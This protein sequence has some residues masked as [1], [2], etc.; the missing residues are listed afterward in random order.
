MRNSYRNSPTLAR[1]SQP[2]SRKGGLS[3]G[4]VV[5]I[6]EQKVTEVK[7]TLF[8]YDAIQLQE[9]EITDIA[10]CQTDRK[11]RTVTWLNIDGLHDLALITRLG[12][13]FKLS[14]LHQEDI[15]NTEQR[16]KMEAAGNYIYVVLKMLDYLESQQ[17][18]KI[19][20]VSFILG[21]N[22]VLSFQE[23]VGDVF[24]PVRERLRKANGRIR[25]MG[26]DY[27]LYALIDVV[28]DHYFFVLEKL[29]EKIEDIQDSLIHRPS[30][31]VLQGIYDLKRQ[32]IFIRKAVW[33][34]R[35]LVNALEREESRLISKS[36]KIYLR[37]VY[38]H[39]IQV[40]DTIETYREMLAEMFEIY[41]SG[42]SNRMNEIMKVLTIISTIFMPLSFLA[43]VYGMN[44]RY[45]PE[46][47]WRWG[48]FVICGTM[49][50]I[51]II[52][53]LIFRKKKW[54]GTNL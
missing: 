19:E 28:V 6:G 52:M 9:R 30:P 31:E 38:D 22:F 24:N 20:Q 40:I 46:L 50:L 7:L 37:D 42:I 15:V 35:E 29:G 33:P 54:F 21:P 41:L 1:S 34:L 27:L 44:F 51:G 16:P 48:Y 11:L 18:F 3:P 53:L 10:E 14:D 45:M 5:H 32:L 39:T 36:T 2:R 26:A 47:E 12:E 8:H 17:Q 25:K 13:D 23:D 49:F 43:G 4:T